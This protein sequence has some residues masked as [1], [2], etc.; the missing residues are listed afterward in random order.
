MRLRVTALS[1]LTPTAFVRVESMTL[2]AL[3]LP[4][5]EVDAAEEGKKIITGMLLVGLT[6]LVVILLGELVEHR[7]RKR[8]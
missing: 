7:G 2:L 3:T 6:F 1:P 8:R 4:L 5:A